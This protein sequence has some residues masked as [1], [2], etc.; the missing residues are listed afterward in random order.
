MGPAARLC[1]SV[2]APHG[3]SGGDGAKGKTYTCMRL[4][5]SPSPAKRG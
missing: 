2:C 1:V 5:P 3:K 4:W